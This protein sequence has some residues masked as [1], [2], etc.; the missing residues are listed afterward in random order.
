MYIN[1]FYKKLI[2]ILGNKEVKGQVLDQPNVKSTR[3]TFWNYVNGLLQQAKKKRQCL[4][5]RK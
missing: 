3:I 1:Y 5:K 2:L 4:L